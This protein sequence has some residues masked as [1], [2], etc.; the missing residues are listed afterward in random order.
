MKTMTREDKD[1][2]RREKMT[3]RDSED[4]M[5][6]RGSR[7]VEPPDVS[8]YLSLFLFLLHYHIFTGLLHKDNNEKQPNGQQ[9]HRCSR[10]DGQQWITTM[11]NDDNDN[12]LETHRFGVSFFIILLC[13]TILTY[14]YKIHD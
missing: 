6:P 10:C 8:F 13:F 12:R 11:D 2:G 14:V 5:Q 4:R 3:T 9:Q 7:C 1:K